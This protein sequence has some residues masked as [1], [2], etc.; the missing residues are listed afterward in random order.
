MS[1]RSTSWAKSRNLGQSCET[2]LHLHRGP[3]Y[4]SLSANE[5][6]CKKTVGV[7][8]RYRRVTNGAKW[9]KCQHL[10][11]LTSYQITYRDM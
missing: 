11:K 10:N 7:R 6:C 5:S 1:V 3:Q 9:S 4:F 8:R 2:H